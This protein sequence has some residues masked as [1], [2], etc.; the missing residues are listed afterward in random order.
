MRG[1]CCVSVF[2]L[3]SPFSR[4]DDELF[5]N[6]FFLLDAFL[7]PLYIFKWLYFTRS[8]PSIALLHPLRINSFKQLFQFYLCIAHKHPLHNF[9][10][11]TATCVL[12]RQLVCQVERMNKQTNKQQHNRMFAQAGN[13]CISKR[14]QR[15]T[16]RDRCCAKQQQS[17]AIVSMHA[18]ICI[19]ICG[20]ERKFCQTKLFSKTWTVTLIT[21][22][23]CFVH[24]NKQPSKAHALCVFSPLLVYL[25]CVYGFFSQSSKKRK[26]Q[27]RNR[28]KNQLPV[29]IKC[30]FVFAFSLIGGKKEKN[31]WMNR[32]EW[33]TPNRYQN[34]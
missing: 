10:I 21:R 33:Y 1:C 8:S 4:R 12:R 25:A 9:S 31:Q 11:A 5:S 14:L 20:N 32:N 30:C 16:V 2:F 28:I 18:Y 15:I 6:F 27:E 34:K 29:W 3:L 23:L 26:K 17:I 22:A 7:S 13:F 24:A 19:N